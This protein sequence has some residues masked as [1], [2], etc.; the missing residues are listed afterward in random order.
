[1]KHVLFVYLRNLTEGSHAE[2]GNQSGMVVCIY[3][4]SH[5]PAWECIG[6]NMKHVLFDCL[7]YL[8]EGSHAEHGNQS[9]MVV[10]VSI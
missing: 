1:M 3:P 5:A 6:C 2:H 7:R 10:C 8:T 4:R 9:G